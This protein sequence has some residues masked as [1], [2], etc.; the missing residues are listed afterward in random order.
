MQQ[1]QRLDEE[2]WDYDGVSIPQAVSTVATINAGT[3]I[4]FFKKVS[5]PQAVSTVATTV[6]NNVVKVA[7]MEVSIPQAVST[8]ATVKS[9]D[10]LDNIILDA[11][12]IPQAVSTVATR[13]RKK[14]MH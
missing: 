12:S 8:V 1:A 6:K 5:I 13:R 4:E 9:G 14:R 7:G 2:Y 10:T 3:L 11:V